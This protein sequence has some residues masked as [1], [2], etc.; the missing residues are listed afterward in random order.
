M[1]TDWPH[2]DPAQAQMVERYSHRIDLRPTRAGWWSWTCVDLDDH[3][4]KRGYRL[5][6]DAA[7]R[8]ARKSIVEAP[9]LW[10]RPAVLAVALIVSLAIWAGIATAIAAAT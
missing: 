3:V 7:Y 1:S 4:A 6:R 2:G 9:P 10:S 5:T 8:A